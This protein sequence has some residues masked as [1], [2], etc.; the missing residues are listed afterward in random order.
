M[1]GFAPEA[2]H[3]IFIRPVNEVDELKKQLS[4]HYAWVILISCC[5]L[6]GSTLGI[7]VNCKG[8][9]ITPVCAELGCSVSSFTLYMTFYGVASALMLM[10]VSWVFERFPIR[11]VLTLALSALC[12]ATALMG[13]SKKLIHWYVLGVVQG[14]SGAFL[15]FVLTPML[16]KNWFVKYRGFAL[17]LAGTFSGLSGVFMN[18]ILGD[19][20]QTHGWRAG[21]CAQGLAA[22]IL[23]VPFTLFVVIKK[24]EDI[25]LTPYGGE[26]SDQPKQR[27]STT[28]KV[29]FKEFAY[30][31]VF[32][33]IVTY[34]TA[35]IQQL[36]NHAASIGQ[37]G[38]VGA[39]MA[40]C[41]MI[42]TMGG[43]MLLG[44]AADKWGALKA[45]VLAVLIPCLGFGILAASTYALLC[46][47]GALMIGINN[48]NHSVIVPLMI[49]TSAPEGTF[50]QVHSRITMVLMLV[51]A[52]GPVLIGTF[53]DIL[54][55]YR[56]SFEIAA[57][58]QIV[59]MGIALKIFGSI[60]KVEKGT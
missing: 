9:F 60:R 30:I 20:I 26:V 3:A 15:L 4:F 23:A 22:F 16:I 50:E 34:G 43:K 7:I 18:P 14:I 55:S 42:G 35:Y 39:V 31:A 13:L 6:S 28:Q 53:Y 36:S 41:A 11:I 5:V 44:I 38:Q 1:A 24:P 33:A 52:F 58:L 27:T 48:A 19:V 2:G 49:A 47:I 59:A 10:K 45:C 54:G 46:Y 32:M 51:A 37:L 8:L 57:I 29:S 12:G 56:V 17:G 25:G 40:S 21:Y